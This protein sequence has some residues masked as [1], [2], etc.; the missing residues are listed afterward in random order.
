MYAQYRKSAKQR[1]F[2]FTLTPSEFANIIDQHCHYCGAG[3]SLKAFGVVR[4]ATKNVNGNF[5]YTGIDRKDSS[6]GYELNNCLPCC[7]TCNFAK[8]DMSYD[9]FIAYLDRLAKFR[10]AA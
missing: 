8:N 10:F 3:P 9:E 6:R 5:T 2:S 4:M 7:K 1:D